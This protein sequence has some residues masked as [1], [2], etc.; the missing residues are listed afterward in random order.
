MS[1]W[2]NIKMLNYKKEDEVSPGQRKRATII[3][4]FP[5]FQL[6]SLLPAAVE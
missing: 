3:L 5:V 6:L 1:I 4:S 2:I